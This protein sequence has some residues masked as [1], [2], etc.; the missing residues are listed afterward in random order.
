M[1]D[2]QPITITKVKIAKGKIK[3]NYDK[4]KDGFSESFQMVSEEKA[5]PEFYDA[6]NILR[7]HIAAIMNLDG[8]VIENRIS[9]KKLHSL[10]MG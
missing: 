8:I 2:K 9:P 4:S 1:N 6:F 10:T 7:E 5:A 3:I